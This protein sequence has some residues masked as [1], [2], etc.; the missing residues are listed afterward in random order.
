MEAAQARDPS[1]S[2]SQATTSPTTEPTGGPEVVQDR[3]GVVASPQRLP[4]T[5]EPEVGL[6]RGRTSPVTGVPFLRH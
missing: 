6:G 1:R 3:N 2:P 5:P 4:P